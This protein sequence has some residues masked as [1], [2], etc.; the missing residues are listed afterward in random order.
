M[1]RC[2]GPGD[3]QMHIQIYTALGELSGLLLLTWY[4]GLMHFSHIL[5]GEGEY[6]H[7]ALS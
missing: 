1:S 4:F 7:I 3:F 5:F 6:I 2:R